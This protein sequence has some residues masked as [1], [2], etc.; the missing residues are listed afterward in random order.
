MSNEERYSSEFEKIQL[1]P[2][3]KKKV[4]KFLTGTDRFL[5]VRDFMERAIEVFLAWEQ[6]PSTSIQ[7]MAKMNPTMAQY[8]VLS[9]MMQPEALA[10]MYG[11]IDWPKEWGNEWIEFQKNNPLPTN[12]DMDEAQKQMSKRK[13][14]KD[15]EEIQKN[16]AKTI[17]FVKNIEFK[18]IVDDKLK[19][20]E[21]DDWPIIS[22]MYSRFLPAKIAVVT[23]ANM[24]RERKSPLINFEDFKTDAYDIAEEIAAKLIKYETYNK[25]KR[26]HK[27]S[28][29]LP[30]PYDKELE[31]TGAQAIKEERYKNKYFGKITKREG[32]DVTHL[33]GLL[34]A[35]GLVKVFSNGKVAKITL[36]ENGM[37]FVTKSNPIFEGELDQSLSEKESRFLTTKCISQRPLQFKINKKII[38]EVLETEYRKSPDMAKDL[39]EICV[40]SIKE[41]FEENTDEKYKDRIEKEILEKS[42]SMNPENERIR[43][44]LKDD[45]ELHLL[46]S[47]EKIKFRKQL[48]QTPIE[49]MRIAVMGRITELGLVHWEINSDSRSEYKI[50]NKELAD[51]L[52]NM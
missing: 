31:A 23:L 4:V 52:M 1:K 9:L 13:S 10:G 49:A 40:K 46:D 41:F 47:E 2:D 48:K 36:T 26:S 27:K 5:D 37:D 20:T 25:I 38:K 39:D 6:N 32:A 12:P 34:S 33:D 44:I 16:M 43:K 30:K 24:I 22:P 35:L 17:E 42:K 7:V 15:F 50:A 14:E 45:E 21:Y 19:Q 18:D 51:S 28:T 3:Q 11:G 29:G 8:Q